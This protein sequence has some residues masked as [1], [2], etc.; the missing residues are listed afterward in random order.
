MKRYARHI[1]T[2]L[3]VLVFFVG[4]GLIVYPTF[5]NWWNSFHQTRAIMGYAEVV[6]KIEDDQYDEIWDAAFRYNEKLAE[7]GMRWKMTEEEIAEYNDLLDIA[8]NG[9]MGYIMIPKIDVMLPLYHGTSEGVLQ[10]AVG[11]IES[12]SLPVGGPGTHTVFSGHRGLPRAKLFTDLDRLVVGDRFTLNVLDK[13]LTYEVDQIRIVEPTD[14]SERTIQEGKD[15]CTLVTCTPYA[16]NSHRL[17]VR[18]HRVENAALEKEVRVTADAIQIDTMY[19]A[20][21][22]AAPVLMI[23]FITLMIA[24]NG[25]KKKVTYETQ[26]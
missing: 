16:I 26:A 3:V 1:T 10:I 23:L 19:V 8:D 13:I 12:S 15:L 9:N 20:P 6:A 5:S 25:K 17:L 21:F 11:H 14:L 2:A 18:G 4:C 22:V 24:P 7:T